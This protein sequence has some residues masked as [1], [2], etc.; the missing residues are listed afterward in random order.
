M[1]ENIQSGECRVSDTE[2]VE[3]KRLRE[4]LQ[5]FVDQARENEQKMR[6]FHEQELNLIS[7]RTLPDLI[8]SI[9]KASPSKSC[10]KPAPL[11]G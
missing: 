4:K 7:S 3:E 11:P 9:T 1:G 8:Q 5:L 6:R 10:G 2:F